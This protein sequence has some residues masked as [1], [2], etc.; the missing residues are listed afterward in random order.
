MTSAIQIA[1][2]L[3][4]PVRIHWSFALIIFWILY[5]V[6]QNEGSTNWQFIAWQSALILALF[7][8][9]V[10]HEFGHALTARR[11]GIQTLDII[12]SPIGGVARLDRMPAKPGQ[13]F[14]VALAGPMVNYG[15]SILLVGTYLLLDIENNPLKLRLLAQRMMSPESNIFLPKSTNSLPSEL[16]SISSSAPLT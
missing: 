16:Q 4:I 6:Y 8:F 1:K 9:V 13:E 5:L 14:W 15:I 10:L 12:L 3:G 2:V 11:Y 7:L